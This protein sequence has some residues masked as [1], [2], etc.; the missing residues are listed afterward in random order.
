MIIIK[1]SAWGG[2]PYITLLNLRDHAELSGQA[3]TEQIYVHSKLMIVDDRYI[4]VGSANIND[5]SLLGDRD[6]EL[7][8]LISDTA[9]GNADL[10]GSGI[11]APYRQFARDL[12]QWAWGEMAGE[13]SGS[14]C[15][16]AG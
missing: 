7:A 2:N 4:L 11:P 9:S 10:D 8:V 16:G 12:R 14:L 1:T 6:S 13:C 15:R 5:R 3:V